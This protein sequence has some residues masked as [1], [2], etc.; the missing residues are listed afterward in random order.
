VSDQDGHGELLL[1]PATPPRVAATEQIERLQEVAA[2]L[3]ERNRQLEEALESR[4]VIEQAKGV[5]AERYRLEIDAAFELLRRASRNNRMRI[6][7]LAAAV[8]RSR[9]TPAEIVPP[10]PQ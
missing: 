2:S 5:L 1:A 4:I 9:E 3:L 6:H 10:R 7:E 8:V